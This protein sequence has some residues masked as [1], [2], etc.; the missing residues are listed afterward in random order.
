M[1]LVASEVQSHT[2]KS[3]VRSGAD[4]AAQ[5]SLYCIGVGAVIEKP[6]HRHQIA[7][8]AHLMEIQ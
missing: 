7:I 5:I 1:A 3:T 4:G 2:P 6:L 8:P